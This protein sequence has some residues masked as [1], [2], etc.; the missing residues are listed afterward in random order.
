MLDYIKF[1]I[2][3]TDLIKRI[4][5]HSDLVYKSEH[6]FVNKNTG[7]I[8]T[9]DNRQY[10]N[11]ILSK[12]PNKLEVS[13][14]LHKLF[15]N[16]LH[17][18]NDFTVNDCINTLENLVSRFGLVPDDCYI[19]NLEFGV[20]FETPGNVSE[21]VKWLR[22]HNKNQFIKYPDLAE[23]YFAGT[24]YFGVKAYNKTLNYPEYAQPNLMRFEG[25]TRQ[26]KYLLSKGIETLSDLLKPTTYS[27][28]LKVL[29][30]EWNNVLIFDKRTKKGKRFC[31][32]DFWL[33]ILENNHRNTF[34][35]TKKKYYKMLGEKGLQNLI[36]KRISDKLDQ[37]KI[38][39]VSTISATGTLAHTELQTAPISPKALVQFPPI[40]KMESNTPNQRE[41]VRLCEVTKL[42]ISMQKKGSE[43]ICS[44]GLKY[45]SETEPETYQ[46]LKEKYLT[47]DKWGL[48]LPDQFYY[49][50]HNVRNKFFNEIHNRKKFE[51]RNYPKQQLQFNFN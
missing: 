50:A 32:T 1:E 14:S 25:K 33:E 49:I 13:G 4:W 7:E 28:L 27:V 36:Y 18:A 12:H 46:R 31:N 6:S 8:R 34:V 29:L 35:N 43:F 15:N 9:V 16:G 23:C 44:A 51:Q 17:N 48:G 3:N 10:V 2:K 24:S 38:C 22:F 20:N 21:V 37:L 47:F 30:S 41:T 40:V 26:S 19:N 45:Y 5:S 11:L 42:N 39:A